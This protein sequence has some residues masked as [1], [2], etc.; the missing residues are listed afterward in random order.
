MYVFQSSP[1]QC[2]SPAN[3]LA[4]RDWARGSYGA[5]NRSL[6][7]YDWDL[8]FMYLDPDQ[9]LHKF[10]HL[11]QDLCTRHVPARG[12]KGRSPPWHK[13]ISRNLQ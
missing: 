11:L 8:E 7:I 13:N 6:S 3:D 1:K 9:M 2:N 12:P 10:T 4:T 5:I